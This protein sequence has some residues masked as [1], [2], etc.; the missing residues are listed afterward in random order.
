MP[1]FTRGEEKYFGITYLCESV[2][3]CRT[4]F[5]VNAKF[6][7]LIAAL[8]YHSRIGYFYRTY[9]AEILCWIIH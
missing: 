7:V 1:N 4:L 3:A 8:Q 9:A 2:C 5:R 6:I